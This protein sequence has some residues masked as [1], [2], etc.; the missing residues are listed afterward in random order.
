MAGGA[1]GFNMRRVVQNTDRVFSDGDARSPALALDVGYSLDNPW[2]CALAGRLRPRGVP[3]CPTRTGAG[4]GS[5]RCHRRSWRLPPR[6]PH[7]LVD[8][9]LQQGLRDDNS[10]RSKEK[11]VSKALCSGS[12]S[13]PP[14]SGGSTSTLTSTTT[15]KG[16]T[17]RTTKRTTKGLKIEC[18][19]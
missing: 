19:K 6:G 15:T 12:W 14:K 9:R 13:R 4:G 11:V 3:A 7:R 18:I 10:S 1:V 5:D 16:T 17:K 8:G 2:L